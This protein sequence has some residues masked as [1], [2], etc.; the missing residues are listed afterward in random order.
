MRPYFNQKKYRVTFDYDFRYVI[1]QC[2][3]THRPHQSGTW[4]NPDIID[5][6]TELHELGYAHSVEVWQGGEIVGGLYGMALGEIFFGESMFAHAS[7]ASKFGFISLV[8]TLEQ[9]GFSLIDCQQETSH[10]V[11]M[12]AEM[13]SKEKFWD[14]IKTN[15][16]ISDEQW[17]PKSSA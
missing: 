9:Q 15:L 5:A 2:S 12:G 16:P 3:Y 1:E 8:K 6:Y 10:L 11:S 4:I 14:H 7:N 13:I 17:M